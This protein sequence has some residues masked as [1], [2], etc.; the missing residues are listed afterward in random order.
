MKKIIT[1]LLSV[2][3]ILGLAAC[4]SDAPASSDGQGAAAETQASAGEEVVFNYSVVFEETNWDP[5]F[6]TQPDDTGLGSMIYETLFEYTM[7]GDV[8]PQLAKGYE[9]SDDGLTYTI[10]L[11]DDVEWQKGY[12]KF[13]SADVKFTIERH[14]DP[15]LASVNATNINLENI[16]SIECP[17]DYTV[18]IKLKAIDVD[19]I[20]RLSMFYS[21][22]M[23]KA[24]ND[25]EGMAA[26]KASPVGTGAFEFDNGTL[27]VR[28]EAVAN[29]N[30]WGDRE[31][32][33]ACRAAEDGDPGRKAGGALSLPSRGGE[34]A[35]RGGRFKAF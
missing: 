10:T 1:L 9:V 17:D 16:D 2:I 8:K 26:L 4:G 6:W 7:D 29:K 14:G 23:C 18:V 35:R 11:R 25:K 22:I 5:A 13:T 24:Y 21:D 32:G 33:N 12:G 31:G 28:T 27:A 3:M 19:L 20:T 15:A 30:W 34:N